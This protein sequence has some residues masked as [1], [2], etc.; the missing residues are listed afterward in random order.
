MEEEYTNT[1]KKDVPEEAHEH[2]TEVHEN[3]PVHHE[4]KKKPIKK[5]TIWK[6]AAAVLAILL[7]AIYTGGFSEG[8]SG[9]EGT[10]EDALTMEE[11][12]DK[13]ITYIN[14]NLLQPGTTA[15]LISTEE[16]NDLYNVKM[17][18]GGRE[19]DSYITKDGELFFPSVVDLN[20]DVEASEAPET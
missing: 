9:R 7:I 19:F 1:E 14:T 20:E 12:A 10:S 4:H 16:T 8:S 15:K 18:I 13:A 5:I 2:K 17:D 11:A 3:K 6:A